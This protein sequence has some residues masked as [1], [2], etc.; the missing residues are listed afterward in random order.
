MK[1]KSELFKKSF[2]IS[3]I[4]FA[5][6]S[7]IIMTNLYFESMIVD[8]TERK[9]NVLI[10]LTHNGDLI[11]VALL[12]CNPKNN[13]ITS[14]AIPD[15]T[16][17]SNGNIL[18][19]L[20]SSGKPSALIDTI[21]DLTGAKVNRYLFITM[22]SL[23][24]LTEGVDKFEYLIRHPFVFNGNEYSGNVY[25]T[26]ELAKAMFTYRNYDASK[27][28]MADMGETFLYNFISTQ[29]N[30]NNM[31]AV[32]SALIVNKSKL[33]LK[34]NLTDDEINAY[35][36]FFANFSSITQNTVKLE[37][38]TM[39]SSTNTYFIPSTNKA[40]KNIFK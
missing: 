40:T 22:D 6:I 20:Y 11:S 24:S 33:N 35:C 28:S 25:M 26:G 10:G 21:E 18:Q 12:H 9:S 14:L 38:E 17:L 4:V 34:T 29:S 3:L 1:I 30:S 23:I 2:L 13:S 39:S 19:N 27:V 32:K 36:D 8:P 5:I 15:N 16:M 37:G 31:E 7:A